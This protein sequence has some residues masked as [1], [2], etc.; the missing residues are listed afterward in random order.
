MYGGMGRRHRFRMGR[1]HADGGERWEGVE[2]EMVGPRKVGGVVELLTG[3]G[4]GSRWVMM[5]GMTKA[6]GL[7]RMKD[8][9]DV[10]GKARIVWNT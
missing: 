4:V 1:G 8:S 2:V 9:N 3:L 5:V 6:E 10:V 7:R